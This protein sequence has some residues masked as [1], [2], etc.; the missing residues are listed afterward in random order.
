V[1]VNNGS[2]TARAFSESGFVAQ[3]ARSQS[4]ATASGK[5]GVP[6]GGGAVD[7]F[8][9]IDDSLNTTYPVTGGWRSYVNNGDANSGGFHPVVVCAE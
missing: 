1:D 3:L 6:V 2:A 5:A 8:Y 4:E 7:G 9:S